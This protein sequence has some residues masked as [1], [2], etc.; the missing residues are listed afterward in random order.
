M[1]RRMR[2]QGMHQIKFDG[3]RYEVSLPWNEHHSLLLISVLDDS[4]VFLG[5]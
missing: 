2:L 3:Q 1:S 4:Q 5:G